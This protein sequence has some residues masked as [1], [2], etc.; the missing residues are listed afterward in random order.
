MDKKSKTLLFILILATVVIVGGTFYKTI[1]LNDFTII[2]E[3]QE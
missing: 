3:T 1:I 2:E